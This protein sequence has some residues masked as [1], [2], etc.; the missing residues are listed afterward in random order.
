MSNACS[1]HEP[2][3]ISL[4]LTMPQVQTFISA[5]SPY[6]SF[7]DLTIWTIDNLMPEK[8]LQALSSIIIGK[9]SVKP[10]EDHTYTTSNSIAKD[11]SLI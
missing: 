7:W 6:P 1:H 9:Y 10:H 8:I 2:V 3:F 4:A 5:I 11:C